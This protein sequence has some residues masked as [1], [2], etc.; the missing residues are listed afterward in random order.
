MSQARED[1]AREKSRFRQL[2]TKVEDFQA[3]AERNANR[4]LE[5]AG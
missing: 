3:Q 2:E 1:L 5:D 4:R